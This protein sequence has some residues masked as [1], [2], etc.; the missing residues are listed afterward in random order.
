MLVIAIL[1]GTIFFVLRAVSLE[2]QWA[3]VHFNTGI[4]WSWGTDWSQS[5]VY[6]I[7]II[8]TIIL[9]VCAFAFNQWYIYVPLFM[10]GINSLFNIIDKGLVDVYGNQIFYNAVVDNLK[11]SGLGF[12]N[13]FAD[14]FIIFSFIWLLVAIVYEYYVAIKKDREIKDEAK[15][16]ESHET[17]NHST[18]E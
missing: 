1:S 13:N 12:T 15:A 7:K 17:T 14:L 18:P 6:L 2:E 4:A 9:I 3:G 8:P 10:G 5:V 11:W 16:K